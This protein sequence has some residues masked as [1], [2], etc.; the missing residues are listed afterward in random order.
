MIVVASSIQM[1]MHQNPNLRC[2][3]VAHTRCLRAHANHPYLE[4]DFTG[5][6]PHHIDCHVLMMSTPYMLCFVVPCRR[7]AFPSS[8]VF[9]QHGVRQ[10][11]C[12]SRL[13][14]AARL[15]SCCCCCRR[16]QAQVGVKLDVKPLALCIVIR[17]LRLCVC[18][19]SADL[20]AAAAA[21]AVE[22]QVSICLWFEACR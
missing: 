7:P 4:V 8:L 9:V 17:H 13:N 11:A 22:A 5:C 3:S 19:K 20:E 21:G 12:R 14:G 16:S 6:S 10:Q 18:S 2:P 15:G 1:A